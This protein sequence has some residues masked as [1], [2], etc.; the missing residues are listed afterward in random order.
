MGDPIGGCK[1][2]VKLPALVSEGVTEVMCDGQA[3]AVRDF[4]T[5]KCSATLAA[6]ED[7]DSVA[8]CLASDANRAAFTA[9]L[10]GTTAAPPPAT[11]PP[12]A[13]DPTR[14]AIQAALDMFRGASATAIADG[15]EAFGRLVEKKSPADR[16]TLKNRFR[17]VARGDAGAE[18]V[19]ALAAAVN[20]APDAPVAPP[21]DVPPPKGKHEK[22]KAAVETMVQSYR[23]GKIADAS[24]ALDDLMIDQGVKSLNERKRLWALVV[25]GGAEAVDKIVKSFEGPQITGGLSTMH[26]YVEDNGYVTQNALSLGLKILAADDW[27][28]TP[29]FALVFLQVPPGFADHRGWLVQLDKSGKAFTFDEAGVT[30]EYGYSDDGAVSFN[31]GLGDVDPLGLVP[32]GIRIEQGMKPLSSAVRGSVGDSGWGVAAEWSHTFLGEEK[33]NLKPMA[34]LRY[35]F[36]CAPNLDLADLDNDGEHYK[37]GDQMCFNLLAGS[38]FTVYPQHVRLFLLAHV[39]SAIPDEGENTTA[40][41]IQVGFRTAF[42]GRMTDKDTYAPYKEK[43]GNQDPI[44]PGV[45]FLDGRVRYYGID[46]DQLNVNL[47]SEYYFPGLNGGLSVY[48]AYGFMTSEKGQALFA[49][50]TPVVVAGGQDETDTDGTDGAVKSTLTKAAHEVSGGVKI[51]IMRLAGSKKSYGTLDINAG[52][53]LTERVEQGE[54][55]DRDPINEKRGYF[56]ATYDWKF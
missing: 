29:Q 14:D 20:A 5:E 50:T 15:I 45:L 47:R 10:K 41:G 18:T 48:A 13:A 30:T 31:V 54:S 33:W 25:E 55:A 46:Y 42:F 7:D 40:V 9:L 6:D 56:R 19:E 4:A 39:Q 21:R 44:D 26:G 23:D 27:S 28:L 36:A 12:P 38:I 17:A 43:P 49:A 51:D 16:R 8:L 3:A 37:A 34:V 2:A 52:A 32:Y 1:E 11:E 53:I 24:V 22:L 35:D